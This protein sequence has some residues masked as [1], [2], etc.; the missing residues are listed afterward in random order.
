MSIHIDSS[1]KGFGDIQYQG[2]KSEKG[3]LAY[4]LQNLLQNRKNY[5]TPE[6]EMLAIIC[7]VKKFWNYFFGHPFNIIMDHHSQCMQKKVT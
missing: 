4:T 7:A 3:V 6:L 2:E 1:I 5:D